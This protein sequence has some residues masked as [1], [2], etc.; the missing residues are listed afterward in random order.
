MASG[1]VDH[2][3]A[4]FKRYKQR[5]QALDLSDVLDTAQPET[6]SASAEHEVGAAYLR[7]VAIARCDGG[8]GRGPYS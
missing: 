6:L 1:G 3:K 2:F 7:T 8:V 4:E 5:L